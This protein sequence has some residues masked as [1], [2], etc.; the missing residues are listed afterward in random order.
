VGH[1]FCENLQPFKKFE[2]Q[3]L[4]PWNKAFL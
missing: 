1:G 4:W 3:G 2:Q